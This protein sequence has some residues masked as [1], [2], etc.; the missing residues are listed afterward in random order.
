MLRLKDFNPAQTQV[1][2]EEYEDIGRIFKPPEPIE[3]DFS[4]LRY[5]WETDELLRI[6]AKHPTI[7]RYLG[8]LDEEGEY[9]KISS[10]HYRLVL[11]EV[12]AEALAFKMLEKRFRKAG[13]SYEDVDLYYHK[14]FSDFLSIAHRTLVELE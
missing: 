4:P 8:I 14:D 9:S 11:A 6:G 12:V 13:L 7:R 1:L 3:E 2:V 10:P 5:K